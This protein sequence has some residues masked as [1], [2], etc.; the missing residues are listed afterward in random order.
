MTGAAHSGGCSNMTDLMTAS[1]YVTTATPDRYAKQ[2]ASHL[3]RRCE[4]REES[5]G[6]RLILDA[7]EC[8]LRPNGDALELRAAAT[9]S[10]RLDQVQAVVGR[11]LE[12]FGQ[13]N[14]LTVR[15][16]TDSLDK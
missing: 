11:H 14:E 10:E 3:G 1:A 15:W 12:R 2:L 16:V 13:R 9:D 8:L 5:D 7:G 6:T 4:V